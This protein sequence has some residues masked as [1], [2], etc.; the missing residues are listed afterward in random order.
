ML[1]S[2]FLLMLV[3]G[4]G[5]P[6]LPN[7]SG[8][9]TGVLR[10]AAGMPAAGVRVGAVQQPESVSDLAGATAMVSIAETDETG[11]YRL[12][13]VPPGRYY[14]AAGRVDFPSFFLFSAF[15]SAVI[16]RYAMNS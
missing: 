12:E 15:R 5:I 13:N 8:T 9:I 1:N 14:I 11:R 10:N 6:V 3:F 2:L 4:Q 16:S 7:E